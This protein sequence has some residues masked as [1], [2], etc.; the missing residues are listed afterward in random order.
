MTL[1]LDKADSVDTSSSL[2]PSPFFHLFLWP[3]TPP[4]HSV[5]FFPLS[6]FFSKPCFLS[7]SLHLFHYSSFSFPLSNSPSFDS[8]DLCSPLLIPLHLPLW[9]HDNP[10][11]THPTETSPIPNTSSLP[12]P[13]FPHSSFPAIISL[14]SLPHILSHPIPRLPFHLLSALHPLLLLSF[15]FLT[16]NSHPSFPFLVVCHPLR[17]HPRLPSLLPLHP[18]SLSILPLPSTMSPLPR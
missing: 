15:P 4:S 8:H 16:H 2:L 14:R 5:L 10:F 12:V 13:S 11:L 7:L 6:L 9:S 3:P 1:H 18:S 17:L